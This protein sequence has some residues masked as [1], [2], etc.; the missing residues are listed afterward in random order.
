MDAGSSAKKGCGGYSRSIELAGAYRAGMDRIM[1]G[2]WN[3]VIKT[4]NEKISTRF[5]I[6]IDVR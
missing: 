4:K 6:P 5:V 2:P 1:A 3:I